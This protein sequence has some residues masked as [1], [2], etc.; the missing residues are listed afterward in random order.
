[1][2]MHKP[3]SDGAR[4]R[5]RRAATAAAPRI[6]RHGF[7]FF[8]A[9][10]GF[11]TMDAGLQGMQPQDGS[12]HT[13]RHSQARGT[14]DETREFLSP[15]HCF[16]L[17]LRAQLESSSKTSGR[18]PATTK[19]T[20]VAIAM[21]VA[22]WSGA[23]QGTGTEGCWTVCLRKV[24]R[25]ACERF[26]RV[27]DSLQDAVKV[28]I[29]RSL[30]SEQAWAAEGQSVVAVGSDAPFVHGAD[31]AAPAFSSPECCRGTVQE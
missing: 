31:S 25:G 4:W 23:A 5:Q 14:P 3:W 19:V 13:L 24:V 12:H 20:A 16:A 7:H 6:V 18:H 26:Q 29:R 27:A 2:I 1:M 9:G 21:A 10:E 28:G 8:A 22:A 30:A 11:H 15:L 17:W